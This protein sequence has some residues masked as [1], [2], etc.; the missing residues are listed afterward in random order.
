[1]LVLRR[2]R[3]EAP[4]LEPVD[5]AAVVGLAAQDLH[6][7][8]DHAAGAHVEQEDPALERAGEGRRAQLDEGGADG[9]PA[10][11]GAE[12]ADEVV[13][14]QVEG[15]VGVTEVRPAGSQVQL[16]SGGGVG[17][18][19]HLVGREGEHRPRPEVVGQGHDL[20]DAGRPAATRRAQGGDEGQDEQGAGHHSSS[21]ARKRARDQWGRGAAAPLCARRCFARCFPSGPVWV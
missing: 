11:E 17:G 14:E 7:G 2:Q 6:R 5:G 12:G 1:M 10:V 18:G 19:Q 4:G 13:A 3:P 15:L 8:G 16:P 9:G 20:G 21:L